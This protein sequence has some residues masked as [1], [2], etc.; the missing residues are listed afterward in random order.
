MSLKGSYASES[1]KLFTNEPLGIAVA[2]ATNATPK[3]M[4]GMME[5]MTARMGEEGCDPVEM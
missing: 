4:S 2:L 3:M 1:A 5:N